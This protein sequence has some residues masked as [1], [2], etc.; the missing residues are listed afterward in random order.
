[1]NETF[2]PKQMYS[3][4]MDVMSKFG[5]AVQDMSKMSTE[6]ALMVSGQWI[7]MMESSLEKKKAADEQYF[8]F[9]R[10]LNSRMRDNALKAAEMA[11]ALFSSNL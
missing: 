6:T 8:K 10:D 9:V 11:K 5:S 1:M 3:N 2:D 4:S 7:T